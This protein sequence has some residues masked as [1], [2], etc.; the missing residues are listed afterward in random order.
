MVER[1]E[2]SKISA[3]MASSGLVFS[4]SGL[5]QNCPGKAAQRCWSGFA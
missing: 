3:E 1:R 4:S 2:V 5:S